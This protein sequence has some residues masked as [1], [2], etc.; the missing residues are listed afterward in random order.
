MSNDPTKYLTIIKKT[1]TIFKINLNYNFQPKYTLTN[2][3]AGIS[4]RDTT[5][6]DWLKLVLCEDQQA[7]KSNSPRSG[8]SQSVENPG[9]KPI[10]FS[11]IEYVRQKSLSKKSRCLLHSIYRRV[12]V[13]MEDYYKGKGIH[14]Q[15]TQNIV[16]QKAKRNSP[17]WTF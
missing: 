10:A 6:I 13:K 11:R 8:N 12:K 1:T 7:E 16:L 4:E 9:S 14:V 5:L 3:Q 15:K 17:Q 2:R